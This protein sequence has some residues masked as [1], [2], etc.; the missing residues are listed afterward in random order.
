[1]IQE[2]E[3]MRNHGSQREN[4]PSTQSYSFQ[5][6]EPLGRGRRTPRQP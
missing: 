5:E 3:E 2:E 6:N 1:M 4:P